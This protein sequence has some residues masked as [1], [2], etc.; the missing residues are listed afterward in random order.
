MWVNFWALCFVPLIHVFVSVLILLNSFNTNEAE[1]DVFLEFPYFLHDPTNVGNFLSGSSAS[2]K[3]SLYIWKFSVQVLL[4]PSLKDLEH[5]LASMWNEHIIW[6]FKHSLALPFFG[7]GMKT[8]LFQSRG[9]CWV[10]QICWHN[11]R[12]TFTAS[13]FRILNSSGGILSPPLA[14]AIVMP[15]KA[16]LTSDSK[17]SGTRWVTIPSWLSGSLRAFFVQF[18]CIFLPPLLNLFCPC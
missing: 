4:K 13:S 17:M 11:E 12:S 8:D 9:H 16:H 15:P 6:Y 3:P 1:V 2:L 5:Y 14:L 18:L 10:F 7:I